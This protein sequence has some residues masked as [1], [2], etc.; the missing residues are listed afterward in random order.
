MFRSWSV[1]LVELTVRE[2]PLSIESRQLGSL[3]IV[4]QLDVALAAQVIRLLCDLLQK[5]TKRVRAFVVV[6]LATHSRREMVSVGSSEE[7]VEVAGS[8]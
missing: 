7:V 3:R 1:P 5:P 8:L 6:E 2:L 4:E